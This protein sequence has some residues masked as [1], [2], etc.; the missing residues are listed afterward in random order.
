MLMGEESHN[1]Y[2]Y[3]VN[4]LNSYYKCTFS[5]QFARC[6]EKVQECPYGGEM[7]ECNPP[8]WVVCP[9]KEGNRI[10]L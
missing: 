5:L 8:P 7:P 10:E 2:V 3:I 6:D 4:I 1:T 9:F